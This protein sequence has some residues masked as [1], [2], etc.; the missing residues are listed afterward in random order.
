MKNSRSPVD[1]FTWAS[2]AWMRLAF[3]TRRLRTVRV[4]LYLWY[5][6]GRVRSRN[7]LT[8][9]TT[10]VSLEFGGERSE[11]IR[12]LRDL[13]ERRLIKI[14]WRP[15]HASLVTLPSDSEIR[16]LVSEH[17]TRAETWLDAQEAA[18]V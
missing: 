1:T 10:A 18:H 4:G 5:R 14:Q 6:A 13:E 3:Q 9:S 12:G 8:V 17:T 7:N 16:R 2:N 11:A 15:R